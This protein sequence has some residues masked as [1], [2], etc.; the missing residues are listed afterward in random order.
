[1]RPEAYALYPTLVWRPC[2][3]SLSPFVPFHLVVTGQH[4]MFVRLD[5]RV[6][7]KLHLNTP[8]I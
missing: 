6:F 5:G 1:M 7:T 4:S 3:E 8:G 2:R